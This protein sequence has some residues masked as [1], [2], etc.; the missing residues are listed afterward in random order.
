MNHSEKDF[1][2]SPKN[3]QEAIDFVNPKKS[4]DSKDSLERNKKEIKEITDKFLKN[5]KTI[6]V[7]EIEKCI[8][9]AEEADL[10]SWYNLGLF[11]FFYS[12]T[13]S[14]SQETKKRLDDFKKKKEKK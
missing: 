13:D 8:Q 7:K 10:D 1:Y 14:F 4:V 11:S 6:S 3:L 12:L 9:N 2:N 5:L